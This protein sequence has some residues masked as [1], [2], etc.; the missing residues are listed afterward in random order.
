MCIKENIQRRVSQQEPCVESERPTCLR[1]LDGKIFL[2][3]TFLTLIVD[4]IISFHVC[5]CRRLYACLKCR[6]CL[7]GFVLGVHQSIVYS[8]GLETTWFVSN[9]AQNAL[10][11]LSKTINGAEVLFD[12]IGIGIFQ[13]LPL[14]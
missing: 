9:V 8:A 10:L 6:S 7:F 11:R 5:L 4:A 1:L 3:G 14:M 12:Q 2:L 13:N